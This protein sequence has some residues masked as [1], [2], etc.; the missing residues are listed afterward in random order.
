MGYETH[1]AILNLGSV[2]YAMFFYFL[3]FLFICIQFAYFNIK[4]MCKTQDVS[5]E[6]GEHENK[7]KKKKEENAIEM[8]D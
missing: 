7:D 1:N 5:V 3:I 2:F 4:N 8:D 6:G